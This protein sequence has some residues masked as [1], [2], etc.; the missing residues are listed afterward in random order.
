MEKKLAPPTRPS[1][2]AASR[3]AVS[4]PS[5]NI[6]RLFPFQG[7]SMAGARGVRHLVAAAL[8]LVVAASLHDVKRICGR[9]MPSEPGQE[10]SYPTRRGNPVSRAASLL[11]NL[12]TTTITPKKYT[13]GGLM[14]NWPPDVVGASR[15]NRAA[16]ALGA[17]LRRRLASVPKSSRITRGAERTSFHDPRRPLYPMRSRS[18][19]FSA[20]AVAPPG[21]P[22]PWPVPPPNRLPG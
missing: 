14:R 4:P 20:H 22:V 18:F 1:R 21:P 16:C 6:V 19:R 10:S 13:L 8:L 7:G 3:G 15:S 9:K 2:P 12:T 5:Q 17:P 11:T